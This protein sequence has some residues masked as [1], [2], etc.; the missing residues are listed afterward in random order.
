ME[1]PQLSRLILYIRDIPKVA[2]FYRKHFGLVPMH[3]AE[4]FQFSNAKDPA[5]NAIQISSRG[6][7]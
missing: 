3:Q 4:G 7:V 1:S 2:T 5:G 6:L